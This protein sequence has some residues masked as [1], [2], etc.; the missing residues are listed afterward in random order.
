MQCVTVSYGKVKGEAAK[1]PY[2]QPALYETQARKSDG[3]VTWRYVCHLGRARRAHHLATQ[4]AKEH[5]IAR[6]L[7]L[8]DDVRHGGAYKQSVSTDDLIHHSERTG[9]EAGAAPETK[10]TG[11]EIAGYGRA[12]L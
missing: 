9:H 8:F 2:W 11:Q 4:D 3:V 7:P 1:Y 10:A 6:S 5:A 12:V